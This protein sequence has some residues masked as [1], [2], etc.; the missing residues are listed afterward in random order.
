MTRSNSSEISLSIAE[1]SRAEGIMLTECSRTDLEQFF[2]PSTVASLAA[3]LFTTRDKP[4][5]LLDLGAGTGTLSA[6]VAAHMPVGMICAVEIDSSLIDSC[7]RTLEATGANI[8]LLCGDA[9]SIE[10][11]RRFDC[12]ILNPPYKKMVINVSCDPNGK[13]ARVP[14]T[15]A[16]FLMRAISFLKNGGEVVAIIPRSWMSGAYYTAFRCELLK[17]CSLDTI[18]VLSS[19]TA[20]FSDFNVL[21]EICIVKLTKGRRQKKVSIAADADLGSE[22]KFRSYYLD[23]ITSG[24]DKVIATAFQH[25]TKSRLLDSGFRASTGKVV[26]HRNGVDASINK[27][28]QNSVALIQ[29]ENLIGDQVVHPLST[30]KKPQWLPSDD[31]KSALM[32]PGDYVLV[33]RF[34]PKESRKRVQGYL[35]HATSAVAVENHINVIHAGDSRHLIPLS[36]SQARCLLEWVNSKEVEEYFCQ[37]AATTQ[38]N[39][40]DLNRMP[41]EGMGE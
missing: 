33:R 40:G 1:A 7:T 8:E 13:Q 2:T 21:Q 6:H 28:D 25:P 18:V 4:I 29:A 34:A 11:H 38:V 5:S 36:P 27:L 10:I 24:V 19:R 22:L 41:F 3:G 17:N 35:L 32:P 12:A 37:F 14:N 23:E 9:L 15:Y 31:A 16:A 26:M 20:A 39:A 30:A